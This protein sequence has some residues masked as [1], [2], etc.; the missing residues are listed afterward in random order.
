M[1]WYQVL[2]G[3]A[4]WAVYCLLCL[5]FAYLGLPLSCELTLWIYT[6]FLCLIPSDC[7]WSKPFSCGSCLF[8]STHIDIVSLSFLTLVMSFYKH[9]QSPP[10]TS[11]L[12]RVSEKQTS[13]TIRQT[14]RSKEWG[15]KSETL[16]EAGGIIL[17]FRFCSPIHPIP[18]CLPLFDP[19]HRE[20][21]SSTHH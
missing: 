11:R 3:K 17:H 19:F 4:L 20:P 16:R 7:N 12:R 6:Q 9:P 1:F 21:Y 14:Q 13:R 5:S 2:K 10:I 15:E 18:F 8:G